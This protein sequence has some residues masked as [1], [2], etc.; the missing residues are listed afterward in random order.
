ML[1][2][3]RCLRCSRSCPLVAP[4]TPQTPKATDGDGKPLLFL[5]W[6]LVVALVAFAEPDPTEA[7]HGCRPVLACLAAAHYELGRAG[8]CGHDGGALLDRIVSEC[9]AH[10]AVPAVRHHLA[11]ALFCLTDIADAV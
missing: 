3:M 6:Q 8:L 2:V 11:Q 1:L 10:A 4:L 5:A 9:L 7:L